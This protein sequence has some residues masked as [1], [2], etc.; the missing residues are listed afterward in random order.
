MGLIAGWFFAQTA[1]DV[2]IATTQQAN[3]RTCRLLERVGAMR[4]GTFEQYGIQ[5]VRFEFHREW[6]ARAAD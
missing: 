3:Q 2:L 6:S 1:D 4:A 5:Q